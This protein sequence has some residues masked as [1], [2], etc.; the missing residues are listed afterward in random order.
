MATSYYSTGTV[1]LVNGSKAVIG[2][3]TAWQLALITN[4]YIAVEAA[5]N[6]LPIASVD[7]DTEIT[8]ELAWAGASG[9]YSYAIQRNPQ[10]LQDNAE[11][12]R[13][14]SYLL[15]EIRNGTLFKYDAA[16]SLSDR[17]FHDAK[18]KGFSYLVLA[19]E[20]ALLYV[21]ASATS[22]DWAG[23]FAYGTGPIGPEGPVGF[24]DFKGDYSSVTAYSANDG[25]R[26]NGSSWVALQST[27]GN[28][29][30][31]LPATENAYWSLLAVKGQDG[32]GTGDMQA[33]TYDPL[34]K[35]ADA[36]ASANHDYDNAT[37]GLTATTTQTA[38]D[39][40]ALEDIEN[41]RLAD[42][43][44]ATVKGRASGAGTGQPTDLEADDLFT[45]LGGLVP[46]RPTSASGV[47]GQWVKIATA[48]STALVLPAGG[49]W[50]YFYIV[51]N[52]S[53]GA[54]NNPVCGAGVAAGGSTVQAAI[55]NMI[56]QGFA[57]RVT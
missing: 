48:V 40:L 20:T 10:Q 2:T 28:A 41:D 42:M 50:A 56:L 14:L 18:P 19:G 22:G 54:V 47:V 4:G 37:S 51:V 39:E 30:P 57:W 46:A 24:L 27:T 6:L 44:Q 21:K 16:G 9:I 32:L 49:T 36:F 13:T 52:A 26:Y 29:P 7:G 23:P 34:A 33:V 31:T 55:S 35:A 3:G 15:S 12:S 45:I 17:A 43:V 38:I 25:V 11:N 1:T 8:A 5:G 53:G